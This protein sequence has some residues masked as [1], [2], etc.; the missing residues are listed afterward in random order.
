M[1]EMEMKVLCE[2][3]LQD[4]T[5]AEK[6]MA[7]LNTAIAGKSANEAAVVAAQHCRKLLLKEDA[8]AFEDIKSSLMISEQLAFSEIRDD[9]ED[10]CYAYLVS[11]LS[12]LHRFAFILK[13]EAGLT[14][15]EIAKILKLKV[16]AAEA[17]LASAWNTM[18]RTLDSMQKDKEE[19]VPMYAELRAK[20]T[21]ALSDITLPEQVE[22]KTYINTEAGKPKREKV[23]KPPITAAVSTTKSHKKLSIIAACLVVIGVVILFVVSGATSTG[24]EYA[25]GYF[26]DIEIENYGTVTVQLNEKAAPLTVEHFI[27]LAESDYYDGKTFHRI[28]EGFMMQGGSL[29]GD[30]LSDPN[31]ETIKGEFAANGVENPLSHTRGAISM[32]RSSSYDSGSTQFFIVHQDNQPSLDGLYAAFGYVTKGMDIVDEICTSAKPLD[33][34]GKIAPEAQPVIKDVTIREA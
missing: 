30:G 2:K 28:M 19:P 31:E 27:E 17:A 6:A 13:T 29:N 12:H 4:K 9:D 10:G 3:L 18:T 8:Y 21:D 15:E 20:L 5:L 16:P 7:K 34:N 22:R 11:Q 26:A 1:A 24:G 25:G 33:N 32:A 23:K 14:V